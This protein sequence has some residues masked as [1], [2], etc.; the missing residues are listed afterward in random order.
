MTKQEFLIE[1][2]SALTG[3]VNVTMVNENIKYYEDY[4]NM[5]IRLGEDE[6]K[7]LENLGN[8]RLIAKSIISAQNGDFV[9][10]KPESKFD[11]I[12]EKKPEIINKII[13]VVFILLIFIMVVLGIRIFIKF[14]PII[15][16]FAL[17]SYI[18]KFFRK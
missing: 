2:Q 11:K 4:I 13:L 17:I 7:I 14:L 6:D 15:V 1:L 12:K 16:L 8:P 10:E 3:Q 18:M 9:D 5:H